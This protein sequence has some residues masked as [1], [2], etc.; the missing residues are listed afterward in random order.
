MVRIDIAAIAYVSSLLLTF[1]LIDASDRIVG[2][3]DVSKGTY[4]WFVKFNGCGGFLISPEFVLTA[5][6]LGL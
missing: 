1:K 2:G 6:E 3:T 4:P 5:G